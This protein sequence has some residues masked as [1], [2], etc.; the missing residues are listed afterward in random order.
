MKKIDVKGLFYKV[1]GMWNTPLEGRYLNFKEIMCFGGAGLGG[2]F[3]VC[4]IGSLITATQ[5]SEVYQIGVVHGPIICLVASVLGLII[6]PIW[7]KMMQNTNTKWGRYKPYLIFLAPMISVCAILSTWQPQNL[8]EQA[9][10]IYAYCV[11]IPTLIICNLWN[12]N[13]NM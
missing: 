1:K 7:G 6:Q 9:R 5:I 13:F 11:C 12:N 2:N 8:T 10:M 4:I 3:I